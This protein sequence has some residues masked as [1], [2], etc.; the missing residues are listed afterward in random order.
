MN[1]TVKSI[2]QFVVFLAIGVTILTL[3][4]NNLSAAYLEDCALKGIPTEDC[5]LWKKVLDDF[6]NANFFWIFIVF[7]TFMFSN[8]SRA[9][10]WQM[11]L[12]PLGYSVGFMNSFL[13]IMLGYF[14]NLGLPRMGE[15]VR[16]G[17]LSRNEDIP[18]EKSMGTI[19]V[20]RIVDVICLL[21]MLALGFLFNFE[22]IWKYFRESPV[23]GI[24]DYWHWLVLAGILS[25]GIAIF[26]TRWAA[27]DTEAHPFIDK[28]RSLISGFV[29]GLKSIRKVENI[30][31][32][33]F[34]SIF[35]WLMYY[36]MTYFCFFAFQPTAHLPPEA[37]LIVFDL[38]AIG[39]VVP[40]PGGMGTYH[41]MLMEGLALFGIDAIN[42]FSFANI[43]FFTIQIFCNIAFGILA[44][45]AL[46]RFKKL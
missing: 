35:I 22:A 8:I 3:L 27:R 11:L 15:F 23:A 43:L 29:E 38:G 9:V 32:F 34:H 37:G 42:G 1:K 2:L 19:V 33:I 18:F 14:A 20:D 28:I 17:A 7:L 16:A 45:F 46:P 39:M 40:S 10:R 21:I 6:K 13:S 26:V 44:L 30:W 31:A 25:L 12:K 4:Y 24:V 5:I 36:L 41:Y